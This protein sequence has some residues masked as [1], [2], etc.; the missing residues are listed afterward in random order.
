M[1]NFT[2]GDWI[3]FA[4]NVYLCVFV[5]ARVWCLTVPA[6]VLMKL[7][8]GLSN[9]SWGSSNVLNSWLRNCCCLIAREGP[10][11]CTRA[12]S[13]GPSESFRWFIGESK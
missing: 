10:V 5:Y 9:F 8:Q 1:V 2:S 11:K 6:F 12:L 13:S 3:T 7:N 4:F